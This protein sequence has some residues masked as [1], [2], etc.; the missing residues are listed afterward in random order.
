MNSKRLAIISTHPIQYNAPWFRLVAERNNIIL[1]VFYTWS[2]VEKEAKYDPGFG[3]EIAWDIPLLEGYEYEFVNNT[4]ASPGTRHYNGIV[5]PGLINRIQLFKP[6]AVLVTGWNFKSHLQCL[7]Y[8]HNKIPVFFRGDSTLIDSQSYFKRIARN[9]ALSWV[10]S[11][12]DRAMYVGKANKDYF[13]AHGL[14]EHQLIFAPHAIDNQRFASHKDHTTAGNTLRTSLGLEANATVF[15]FAGKLEPKKDPQLLLNVWKN[16]YLPDAQLVFVGNGILEKALKEV[17]AQIPSIHFVDFQNQQQMPAVYAMA[18]IFVLPSKGPG[19]TWGLAV[20]EAMA[21]G[22]PVL[23][24]DACGCVQD[25]V[26]EGVNGW[27]FKAG[28]QAMLQAKI[29]SISTDK[30]VLAAMGKKGSERIKQYNFEGIASA[31]E[32]SLRAITNKV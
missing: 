7:R 17:A 21:A 18:D 28:D 16:L 9:L 19:E 3:K 20:N 5:N 15:L 22:K 31:I 26:E 24:S 14:K 23:V 4:S 2:Q 30:N 12:I 10:F 11:H 6:D 1:K 27:I 32:N 8:F 13:K 29:E 25:L